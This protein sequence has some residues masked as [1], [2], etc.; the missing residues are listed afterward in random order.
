M[1]FGYFGVFWRMFF[2]YI[3]IPLPPPPPLADPEDNGGQNS[4]DFYIRFIA[5]CT[6]KVIFFFFRLETEK[7]TMQTE[8]EDTKSQLESFK[9]Y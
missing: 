4:T 9:R 6:V 1:N 7:A 8:L 3:G 5:S 2:G